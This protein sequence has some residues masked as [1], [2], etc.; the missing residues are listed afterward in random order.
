MPPSKEQVLAAIYE[1]IDEVNS[2]FSLSVPKEER[3]PLVG[4]SGAFDSLGFV[5]FIADLEER[6]Q[7]RF[8]IQLSLTDDTGVNG[9]ATH[10]N[11]VNHLATFILEKAESR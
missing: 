4:N 10:L 6:C 7:R 9:E 11:S 8:G 2:Q 5:N 1:S 3:T